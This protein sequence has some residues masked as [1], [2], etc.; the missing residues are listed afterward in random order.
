LTPREDGITRPRW[1]SAT[2]YQLCPTSRATISARRPGQ[3]S[4]WLPRPELGGRS[5]VAGSR[6]QAPGRAA[7]GPQPPYGILDAAVS[8]LRWACGHARQAAAHVWPV[9]P[10]V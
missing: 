5:A 3:P 1:Y 10:A 2:G 8:G 6:R 9:P 7:T 4:R